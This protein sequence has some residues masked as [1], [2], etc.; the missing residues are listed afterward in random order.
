MLLTF[1][2]ITRHHHPSLPPHSRIRL[3]MDKHYLV[4]TFHRERNRDGRHSTWSVLLHVPIR[5]CSD[6]VYDVQQNPSQISYEPSDHVDANRQDQQPVEE[7]TPAS[8]IAYLS[9]Q[10]LFL[11]AV[12]Q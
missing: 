10:G 5:S 7:S 9:N 4:K 1:A 12:C 3:H 6:V 2:D 8:G 11:E